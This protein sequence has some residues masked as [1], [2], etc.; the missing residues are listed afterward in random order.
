MKTVAIIQARM[1]SSRLP[2]KILADIAGS[3]MLLHV[4]RR[5]RRCTALDL[6][7]VAT[8]VNATD[9]DVVRLCGANAIPCCR[10]SEEDVLDRYYQAARALSADVVVRITADCPLLDPEVV[11]KVVAAFQ[12]SNCDYASNVLEPTYPDGLDTEVMSW[13]TLERAWRD[14]KLKSER[15]HVTLYIRNH[16]ELFRLV[17]VKHE[18][19]LSRLRWTVDESRDLD[20]VRTV[21]ARLGTDAFGMKETMALLRH[22]PALRELNAGI[23]RNEGLTK[24]LQAEVMQAEK[25]N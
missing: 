24:S 8:T 25:S 5:A 3:A 23:E 16:P 21:F 9:D 17:N 20:L 13:A 22:D 2:G 14:A 4:V 6:V 10:G 11:D 12:A 18:E 19:D 1:T 15:E 7:A